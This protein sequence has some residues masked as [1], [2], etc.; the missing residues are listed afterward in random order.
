MNP[1]SDKRPVAKIN[2]D[3]DLV[4][5][6]KS[7]DNEGCGFKPGAKVCGKCGA[8]AVQ[9]KADEEPEEK[10][11]FNQ[12]MSYVDFPMDEDFK[13]RRKKRHAKRMQSMGMKEDDAADDVFLCASSRQIKSA[14]TG[15]CSDCP[16]GCFSDGAMPDLLEIEA[17]TED[18]LGLKIHASG[19][20]AE[21]CQFVVQGHRK[22]DNQSIEVYWT[23]DG[24][25]DGWFR[26]PE[27]ELIT[28]G[29]SI[30]IEEAAV[31]ALDA[32]KEH[33]GHESLEIV[34][35]GTG[36]LDGRETTVVE[37][38]DGQGQSYDV[39]V[40]P[41]GDV[42]AIDEI[43]TKSDEAAH[44]EDRE[45]DEKRMFTSEQRSD[46]AE[47]GEALPDGSYPIDNEEDL[48]NAIQAFGR[49][50]DPK[51]AKAHIIMRARALGKMD[52]LPEDWKVGEKSFANPAL[53]EL[54]IL[55]AE[56]TLASLLGDD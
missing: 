17:M 12:G 50:K 44:E 49:A 48:K 18:V 47:E 33:L 22:S 41:S 34:S 26:I 25:L 20:G 45:I 51:A 56:L 36:E 15:P 43:I 24:E 21:A 13:K 53:I 19:Y 6:A 37:V 2:A 46:M 30:P 35:H 14:S 42:G 23:D 54:E 39:H 31:K 55:E 1:T 4:Q 52:M 38:K 9:A 7:T 3:G 29:A 8:L 27:S 28:K 10:G 5:C 11:A 40:F 32:M 16:G